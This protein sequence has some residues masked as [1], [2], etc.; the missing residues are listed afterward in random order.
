MKRPVY[1]KQMFII[2]HLMTIYVIQKPSSAVSA[3]VEGD[4]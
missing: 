4:M 2:S 3:G 1:I